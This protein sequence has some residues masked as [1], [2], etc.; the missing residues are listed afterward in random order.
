MFILNYL[1][2]KFC[3]LELPEISLNIELP[4]DIIL[5][6]CTYLPLNTLQKMAYLDKRMNEILNLDSFWIMYNNVKLSSKKQKSQ[7]RICQEQVQWRFTSK[8]HH[9]DVYNLHMSISRHACPSTYINPVVLC[10]R[11]FTDQ[12]TSFTVR[13]DN[14]G[15][16]LG[17]GFVS[18]DFPLI[19]GSTMGKTKILSAAY[20]DQDNPCLQMNYKQNIVSKINNDDE[21][22]VLINQNLNIVTWFKNDIF[23]G[24]MM[25]KNSS[26][27]DLVLYPAINLGLKSRVTLI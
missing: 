10:D 13:V 3:N 19:N 27:K 6:I 4:I 26:W 20:F 14:L 12:F 18:K 7:K 1:K 5:I 22:R 9:I 8:L 24:S 15:N 16:W 2:S 11:P 25:D 17:I 23:I 21:I